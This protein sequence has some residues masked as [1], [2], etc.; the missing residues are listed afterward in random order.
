MTG[1]QHSASRIIIATPRA[2]F[3]AFVDPE[4]VAKWRP[5]AGLTA[6]I[7]DFDP[8]TGGGY[9]MAFVYDDAA[10]HPGKSTADSDV[11]RGRFV[12]LVPDERIVEA[13]EFESADPAFSGTMTMTTTL[14]PVT[15]GTK[16]TFAATEV[17]AGISDADHKAGME[18]TLKNLANLLE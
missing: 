16:V 9:R 6:R 11:F 18:S 14:S 4:V 3:R 15:G 13:V 12:E 17:P 8:R 2:V 5:P 10:G 7:F 1:R